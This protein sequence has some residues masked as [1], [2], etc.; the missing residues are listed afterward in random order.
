[1]FCTTSISKSSELYL[2]NNFSTPVLQLLENQQ[3]VISFLDSAIRPS[4]AFL[5]SYP[6]VSNQQP[7]D[8]KSRKSTVMLSQTKPSDFLLRANGISHTPSSSLTFPDSFTSCN[9]VEFSQFLPHVKLPPAPGFSS[10]CY[11]CP[12]STFSR[13][14]NVW[15][16]FISPLIATFNTPIML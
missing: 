2:Q 3:S 8:F 14:L 4:L 13:R 16:F 7:E 5:L 9:N 11:F 15:L 10:C 6:Q 1:M 12:Q